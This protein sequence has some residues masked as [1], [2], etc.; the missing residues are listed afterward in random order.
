MWT[1]PS[2]SPGGRGSR[3]AGD[4]DREVGVATIERAFGHG[5]SHR[6]ADGVILFEHLALDAEQL[7]LRLLGVGDEAP[8]EAASRAFDVGQQRG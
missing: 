2:S 5:P 6:F 3:K 7:R 4:A 8:L 1:R